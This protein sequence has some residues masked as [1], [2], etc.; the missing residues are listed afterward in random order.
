MLFQHRDRH[1]P[2]G[3]CR[4]FASVVAGAGPPGA[5]HIHAQHDRR[6]AGRGLRR[7]HRR[8][9][10]AGR[11]ASPPTSTTSAK[12]SSRNTLSRI[13]AGENRHNA[14]EPGAAGTLVIISHVK[15]WRRPRA[16]KYRLPRPIIDFIRPAS[17]R[18]ARWSISIARPCGCWRNA[19]GHCGQ[20]PG[21]LSSAY[22]GPKPQNARARQR[23]LMLADAVEQ[24]RAGRRANPTPSVC[25]SKTRPRSLDEAA[26][27]W[28][29][30]GKC[31]LT[32]TEL[33]LI[34]E[35]VFV[36]S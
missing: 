21:S 13:R 5:G 10:A 12:C 14:L 32:L 18:H 11:C 31:G 23:L 28:A 20:R 22:P 25:T 1:Q 9:S 30:R 6:H 26:P 16:S 19:A 8:Q 35:A 29:I 34:E 36:K 7:R 2:A 15:G 33:H 17:R 24:F 3:I 4:R 27:G